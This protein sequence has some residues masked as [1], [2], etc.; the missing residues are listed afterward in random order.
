M[1][2]HAQYLLVRL[3]TS[4]VPLHHFSNLCDHLPNEFVPQIQNARHA[5]QHALASAYICLSACRE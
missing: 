3:S 5:K 1:S 2:G 4:L